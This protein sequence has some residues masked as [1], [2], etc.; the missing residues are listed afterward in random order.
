MTFKDK[1]NIL[2]N[3]HHRVHVVGVDDSGHV[4]FLCDAVKQFVNDK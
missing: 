3:A 2:T 4:K 1:D